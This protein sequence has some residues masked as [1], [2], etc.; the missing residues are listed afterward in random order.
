M[1]VRQIV[2]VGC[3]LLI[4][5]WRART[6]HTVE[7][8]VALRQVPYRILSVDI[9]LGGVRICTGLRSVS[10]TPVSHLALE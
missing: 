6:G 4:P 3:I 7:W 9:A 5:I 1:L 2:L 10:G 8:F